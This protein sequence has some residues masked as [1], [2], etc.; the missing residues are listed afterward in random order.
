MG[1]KK[2]T[3]GWYRLGELLHLPKASQWKVIKTLHDSSHFGKS[4]GQIC[5]G[6]FS[7]KELKK[8]IQRF[9]KHL[10]HRK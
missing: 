2:K 5:K 4:L 10:V 6:V 1:V 3:N 9:V 7:G 8:T